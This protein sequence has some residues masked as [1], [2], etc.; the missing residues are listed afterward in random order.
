[1]IFGDKIVC[2]E[3]GSS[4]KS[5]VYRYLFQGIND[6]EIE[7]CYHQLYTKPMLGSVYTVYDVDESR[8]TLRLIE[9]SMYNLVDSL[10]E[11]RGLPE[12]PVDSFV[13]EVN[14]RAGKFGIDFD[15][16]EIDQTI[17]KSDGTKESL[18]VRKNTNLDVVMFV[19]GDQGFE[20]EYF[21]PGSKNNWILKAYSLGCDGQKEMVE[22]I[23]SDRWECEDYSNTDAKVFRAVDENYTKS[24]WGNHE[25]LLKKMYKCMTWLGSGSSVYTE[26]DADTYDWRY[27]WGDFDEV[28]HF[29]CP[30]KSRLDEEEGPVGKH[31][32]YEQR[33][34]NLSVVSI[35]EIGVSTEP[36]TYELPPTHKSFH[37]E[38]RGA[39]KQIIS[40]FYQYDYYAPDFPD[41]NSTEFLIVHDEIGRVIKI[42]R[43]S[44]W[45]YDEL[46]HLCRFEESILV[47][48]GDEISF[49]KMSGW[50]YKKNNKNHK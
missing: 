11:L 35:I 27:N 3:D 23:V 14:F 32:K 48:Y 34:D 28:M 16:K 43:L 26:K 33:D 25:L 9:L 18:C 38:G 46:E 31:Y 15:I 17:V 8:N 50:R 29:W 21:L 30:W 37:Y 44:E 1:M 47:K 36:I 10:G 6:L 7:L 41:E 49:K 4:F 40:R 12:F 5:R 2:I 13:S 42:S 45:G 20:C 39:L 22:K 19:S 24:K